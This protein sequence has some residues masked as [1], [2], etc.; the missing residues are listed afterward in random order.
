MFFI[1]KILTELKLNK[2]KNGMSME[3]RMTF[4]IVNSSFVI[5]FDNKIEKPIKII[6]L[7]I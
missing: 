5:V 7:Q 1:F 3:K 2:E 4:R 6:V